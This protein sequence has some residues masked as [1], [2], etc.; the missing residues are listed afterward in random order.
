MNPKILA[1]EAAD[2][3]NISLQGLH[4]QLKTKKLKYSKLGCDHGLM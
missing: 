3:L 2:I 1:S 4:K